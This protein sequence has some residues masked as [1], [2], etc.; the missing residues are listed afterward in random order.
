MT[1]V[2]S[3]FS[4]IVLGA[5]T[6]LTPLFAS[7]QGYEFLVKDLPFISTVPSGSGLEAYLSAFFQLGLGIAVFASVF[8]FIYNGVVYMTSDVVGNKGKATEAMQ[9]AVWGL[10]LAL[11]SWLILNQINPNLVDFKLFRTLEVIR[12]EVSTTPPPPPETTASTTEEAARQAFKAL[13]VGINQNSCAPGQG[14]PN[15]IN[16]VGLDAARGFLGG[17]A[18]ALGGCTPE[19]WE[20]LRCTVTITGGT[21][22]GHQTHRVGRPIFDIRFN[23]KT[24]DY[25][26]RNAS[27]CSQDHSL[28]PVWVIRNTQTYFL[29]EQAGARHWHIC[30]KRGDY[31]ND[32]VDVCQ[33]VVGE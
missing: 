31:C 2:G 30:I 15:C 5:G 26:T 20:A 25:I 11:S 8:V 3:L 22:P 18:S 28:G 33:T 24:L 6:L 1:R 27:R 13:G 21:E 12:E 32:L 14:V 4:K 17:L 9:S 23:Q 29:D 10:I 19:N 7:A 16:V